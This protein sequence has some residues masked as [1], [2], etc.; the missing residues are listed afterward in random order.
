M[1]EIAI[2]RQRLSQG[3]IL[4]GA[5]M[6]RIVRRCTPF[7][8]AVLLLCLPLF[9]QSAPPATQLTT[10]HISGAITGVRD[11]HAFAVAFEGASSRMVITTEAGVYEAD[12][13]LGL[14]T[15][16]VG[17]YGPDGKIN[18]IY[19]RRPPFR[20]TAPT[21]FVFD[22]SLPRGVGCDGMMLIGPNGGPPTQEQRDDLKAWCA[23]EEFFSV[24]SAGVPF[25]I[26]IWGGSHF[27]SCARA[28]DSVA[29]Q[30]AF[31]TY[32]TLS[33]R[34]DD[35]TYDPLESILEAQG[36]V[37]TQDESG[38]HRAHSMIFWVHDGQATLTHQD[39]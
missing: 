30:H 13:P 39:R 3:K 16:T 21:R 15:I 26:H 27:A 34:A 11:I 25:E 8:F 6:S 7:R 32:N 33:V 31:A 37:E 20:L 12:L 19:Y 18:T 4:E 5:T 23:G 2:F 29:C 22:I 24:P 35:I 9:G 28:D 10:F 38:A 14:W 1:S 36:N 17:S